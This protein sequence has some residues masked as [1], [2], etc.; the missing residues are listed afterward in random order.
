MAFGWSEE[1]TDRMPR[2]VGIASQDSL[3]W[4]DYEGSLRV[5]APRIS[6][7]AWTSVIKPALTMSITI[8]V[9]IELDWIRQVAPVPTPQAIKRLLVIAY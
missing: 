3:K 9:V 7:I 5:F 6:P 1:G 4:N 8:T 2:C